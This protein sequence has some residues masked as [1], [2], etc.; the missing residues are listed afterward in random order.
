VVREEEGMGMYRSSMV[1]LDYIREAHGPR[2]ERAQ[3]PRPMLLF[4][5]I[6]WPREVSSSLLLFPECHNVA[7]R[8][9]GGPGK[10]ITRP[11][12]FSSSP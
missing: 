9:S 5:V 4:T 7:K 3:R 8:G 2:E 12:E 1:S 6:T 10:S 11:R